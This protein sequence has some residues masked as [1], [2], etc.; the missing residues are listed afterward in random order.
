LSTALEN[1]RN[2]YASA[3]AAGQ[4]ELRPEILAAEQKKHE[5]HGKIKQLEKTIRNT[6]IT[7]HTK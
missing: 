1:A 4:A 6:E 2:S 5:L 3:D 7:S